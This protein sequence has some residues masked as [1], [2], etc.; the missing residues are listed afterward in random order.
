M[1]EVMRELGVDLTGPQ[2]QL[3]TP[4]LAEEADAGVS[5]GRGDQCPFIPGKRCID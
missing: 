5:M 2:R 4:N 1:V 3:L